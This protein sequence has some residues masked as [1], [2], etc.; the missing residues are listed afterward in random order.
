MVDVRL[1]KAAVV[2]AEELNFSRA[3]GQLGI[4]QPALSKQIAELEDK[5]GLVLFERSSQGVEVTEAGAA[6]VE[7]ARLA[8]SSADRAVHSARAASAGS[9]TALMIGKSP[10]IDPFITSMMQTIRLP[11]FPKLELRISSHYSCESLKLLRSG[12]IDLA[13]VIAM[14]E[15]VGVSGVQIGEDPFYVALPCADPLCA[16]SELLVR[17]LTGRNLA[18]LERQV[19]PPIADQ[20][21]KV[22]S[23]EQVHPAEVRYFIQPE[24]AAGLV[25]QRNSLA[26]LPKTAAWRVSDEII[27]IRPLKDDRLLLRTFLAARP[28]ESSRLVSE[29]VRATVRR[30]SPPPRQVSLALA[31]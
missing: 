2:L 10:N 13:I 23:E 28:D 29:F 25:L 18:L 14:Q 26:L 22:F 30:L 16:K 8:L 3:A 11:L 17:D 1:M 4:T 9:D 21:Q 27:T 5:V 15:D 6:F 12:E 19:N 24:E 31:V 7:H 20:V